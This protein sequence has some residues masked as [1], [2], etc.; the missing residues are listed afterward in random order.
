MSEPIQLKEIVEDFDTAMLVTHTD[1]DGI[2]AR[3]MQIATTNGTDLWF[4]SS[5]NSGKIDEIHHHPSVCVTLQSSNRY[6]SL[7]GKMVT[8]DD[9]A[10]IHELWQES[11]KA[12]FPKGKDDPAITLLRFDSGEGEY[13]DNSGMKG[14]GLL[15]EMGRAYL[16]GDKAK[17]DDNHGKV[18]GL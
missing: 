7:S 13:W 14:V 18:S 6:V 1:N 4:I 12:W 5:R 10:K 3:P 8:V 15:L 16:S 11:W 2:R 9:R 17:T